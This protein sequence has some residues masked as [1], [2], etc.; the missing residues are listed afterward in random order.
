[1][2]ELQK[3]KIVGEWPKNIPNNWTIWNAPRPLYGDTAWQ[4]DFIH[5]IFYA[6]IDPDSIF[7]ES[8]TKDNISLDAWQLEFVTEEYAINKIKAYYVEKYPKAIYLINKL[9]KER[10]INAFY[11]NCGNIF[12]N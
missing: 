2:R 6:A 7:S 9:S 1:M 11:E 3:V 4:G 12:F 8:N 5:G 10:L